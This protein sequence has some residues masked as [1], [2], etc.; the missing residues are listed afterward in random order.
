MSGVINSAN[1]VPNAINNLC[2][3]MDALSVEAKNKADEL[4]ETKRQL[5][6]AQD[7]IARLAAACLSNPST[8][9]ELEDLTNFQK[10]K[11]FANFLKVDFCD[12]EITEE[13]FLSMSIED[14]FFL[15]DEKY[16]IGY[17]YCG[18]EDEDDDATPDQVAMSA[19]V[20]CEA[21]F[22][23]QMKEIKKEMIAERNAK[24]FL[25]EYA[26]E[27]PTPADNVK[28]KKKKKK[29]AKKA[30]S[31]PD[32][33]LQ[34][35]ATV[36][37]KSKVEAKVEAKPQC[38]P[39]A[40]ELAAKAA[41]AE[42]KAKVAAEEAEAKAEA[43]MYAKAEKRATKFEDAVQ[44][45]IRDG[46]TPSSLEA[47]SKKVEQQEKRVAGS[48]ARLSS[49]QEE[50]ARRRQQKISVLARS[51]LVRFTAAYANAEE[52][53]K[54]LVENLQRQVAERGSPDDI[55]EVVEFIPRRSQD[56][57]DISSHQKSVLMRA[58]LKDRDGRLISFDRKFTEDQIQTLRNCALYNLRTK[59]LDNFTNQSQ[60]LIA[61]TLI[62]DA[63]PAHESKTDNTLLS[64]E[65]A[66]NTVEKAL[67][68]VGLI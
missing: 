61:A 3:Q 33:A 13:Q 62:N 54:V 59:P 4:Q 17:G 43:R 12:Y 45:E 50:G 42:E 7:E 27:K 46:I 14:L 53:P 24:A 47:L 52:H 36:Q 26:S 58:Q 8:D 35:K 20:G 22:H 21:G 25:E 60:Q 38:E 64:F 39:T 28:K 30:A 16:E 40:E 10:G 65:V 1:S 67:E 49:I 63:F 15:A 37:E 9:G 56:G 48:D 29:K 18:T 6:E 31:A 32:H 57:R 34:A 23:K 2:D 55:R 68:S 51:I 19:Y 66:G 41:V 5:A 44:K 11:D